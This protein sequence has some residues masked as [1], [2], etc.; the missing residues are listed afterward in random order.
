MSREE[1]AAKAHYGSSPHAETWKLAEPDVRQWFLG[2]IAKGLAA[3][4]AYDAAHGIRRTPEREVTA[5][6]DERDNA[7]AWADKLAAALAPDD[8][9]GEHSS[10]NDPWANAL[11][12][13]AGTHRVVLSDDTVERAARGTWVQWDEADEASQREWSEIVRAVLA[14][15]VKEER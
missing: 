8:V 1:A 15:A 11:E 13:A 4:D 12:Y 14:A 3:A 9:L 6:I 5:L 2:R 7:Q 10:M